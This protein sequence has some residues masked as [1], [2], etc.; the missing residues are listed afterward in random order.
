METSVDIYIYI[1]LQYI[2]YRDVINY[3]DDPENLARILLD[4]VDVMIRDL[5]GKVITRTL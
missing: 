1:Y 5:E 3:F 4:T 2:P